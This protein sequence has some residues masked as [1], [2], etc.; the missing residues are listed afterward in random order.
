MHPL[1]VWRQ[2]E[3]LTLEQLGKKLGKSIHEVHR[4]ETGKVRAITLNDALAILKV[5]KGAVK[6]RA[7]ARAHPG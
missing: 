7:L 3:D 1:R 6:I 2:T 5:T 4:I